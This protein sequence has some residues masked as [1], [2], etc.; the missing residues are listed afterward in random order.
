MISYPDLWDTAKGSYSSEL[1]CWT[2]LPSSWNAAEQG[3]WWNSAPAGLAQ[4]RG[5]ITMSL[6]KPSAGSVVN[7]GEIQARKARATSPSDDV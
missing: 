6:L 7:T 2:A 1:T 5:F 4:E 3:S